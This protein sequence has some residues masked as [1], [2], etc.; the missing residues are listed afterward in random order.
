[1]YR[2]VF[3][4]L[5]ARK[6]SPRRK[7]LVLKGAKQV[8]KTWLTREFAN[9]A[10]EDSIYVSFDRDADAAKIFAEVK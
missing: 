8:G 5:V 1:M 4:E 10:Y 2:K 7:P 6:A 9:A 3:E